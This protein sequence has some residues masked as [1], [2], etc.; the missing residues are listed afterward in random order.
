MDFRFYLSLFMRR[1]YWFLLFVIIGSSIGLTLA[2]V[3]PA[4]YVAR[5]RLLVESEQIPTELAA[6][7]VQTEA[8]E[9]IQIIQQRILTRNTLIEMANRFDIYPAAKTQAAISTDEIVADLR[10]RIQIVTTGGRG[11]RGRGPLQA[12]LI[13]VSF[14]AES[15][16][17]SAK[18]ANE[19]V[20]LILRQDTEMR[21][22][23]ARQTLGFFE[24]EVARLD[25]ELAQRGKVILEFKEEHQEAL[26]DS[27][28]FRR[29]QQAAYQE[30]LLQLEREEAALKDR[31]ERAVRLHDVIAPNGSS[32]V[33]PEQRKLQELRDEMTSQLAV[34][35]PENPRIKLLKAK[36]E[37]Q[38]KVVAAQTGGI[39][40]SQSGNPASAYEAQLDELDGQLSF[41]AD[42]KSYI[43]SNLES[44]LV[45]IEATPGNSIAIDA[46][47]R[48]YANIRNQYDQAVVNKARAETG[49]MIEALSKGQRISVIEQAVVPREPERPNRTLIAAGGIGGGILL[50]FAVVFLLELVNSGIRRPVDLTSKL[51]ITPL[52]TLPYLQTRREIWKRRLKIVLILAVF[53]LGIPAALL[54]L[55]FYYMPIDELI[56]I[57]L[58]RVRGAS[59]NTSTYLAQV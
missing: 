14:S 33:Q 19:V 26:P 53:L 55:H 58:Q 39:S 9:Q 10:E 29:S 30:R 2:Q 36:I 25:Q 56:D 12:T 5:A 49:D 6:S 50:G 34:L 13:A 46:L 43:Q 21:T 23:I 40:G 31:R 4:V 16:Q 45:S 17:L 28:E 11:P 54:A 32:I 48:D 38:E 41:I 27:L 20:T 24:Q 7:T 15:A 47:E 22:G 44:L 42:Q 37:A 1:I 57:I 3:L 52:A 51:G 8:S 59:L 35:A 18:I